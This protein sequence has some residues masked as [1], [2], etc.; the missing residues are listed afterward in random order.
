MEI[1]EFRTAK[2]ENQDVNVLKE[3]E[4]VIGKEFK[5]VD[6]ANL[7]KEIAFSVKEKG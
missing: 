6:K 7:N 4:R 3:I 2:L 5:I 1:L